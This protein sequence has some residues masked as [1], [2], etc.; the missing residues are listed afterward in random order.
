[1][2]GSPLAKMTRTLWPTGTDKV[3]GKVPEAPVEITNVRLN[4]KT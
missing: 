3:K 2:E 1:M 4:V